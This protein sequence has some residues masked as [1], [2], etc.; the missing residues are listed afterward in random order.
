MVY[1]LDN[2][3]LKKLEYEND[4]DSLRGW[5]TSIDI[6]MS[7]HQLSV[8][9]IKANPAK[10]QKDWETL[11]YYKKEIANGQWFKEQVLSKIEVLEKY[12]ELLRSAAQLLVGHNEKL[13]ELNKE[14]EGRKE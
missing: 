11:K 9:E 1:Y 6:V 12:D 4:I 8:K 7:V 2:F 3:S 13:S 5:L 10:T 14:I